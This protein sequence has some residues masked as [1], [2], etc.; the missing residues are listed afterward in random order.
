MLSQGF[1]Q[2][3][4]MA[5]DD[6]LLPNY[7]ALLACI[8]HKNLDAS[9]ALRLMEIQIDKVPEEFDAESINKR[10]CG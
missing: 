6:P 7:L 8:L 9:K 10:R 3:K 5:D 1:K 4:T 2:K